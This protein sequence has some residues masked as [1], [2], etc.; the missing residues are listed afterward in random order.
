MTRGEAGVLACCG[1]A[2][3]AVVAGWWLLAGLSGLAALGVGALAS[4]RPGLG[5]F[6]PV[7]LNVPAGI[8]LTIDDGPDPESTPRLLAILDAAGAHATFFFLAD[9]VIRYPELVTA[10]IAGGHEVGLHGLTHSARL[11]WVAPS[12]GEAWLREGVRVLQAAGAPEVRSF[13]PPFGV[14][15]PRLFASARAAG[16]AVVWVSVRTGDGVDISGERLRKRLASAVSGDIVLI[17][18]GNGTTLAELP[19][20][21]AGWTAKTRVGSLAELLP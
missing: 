19:A 15:S 5:L 9:R 7:I 1:A 16:L 21:L 17:H 4:A 11:T 3:G 12:R 20:A 18:E 2:V 10:V 6:G 13:R 14:V 8:A